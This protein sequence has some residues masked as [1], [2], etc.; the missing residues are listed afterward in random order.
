M[1]PCAC[2]SGQIDFQGAAAVPWNRRFWILDGRASVFRIHASGM[3]SGMQL[4]DGLSR[5]DWL[6]VGGLG[7]LGL[8]LPALLQGRASAAT[9][10][11]GL[12]GSFGKTKS[13]II[14]GLLGGP[15]QHETWDPKPDAPVEVRGEFKHIDS[16]LPGL[17]V[18]ELM[19]QVAQIA[20]KLAVLRAVST[21]DNAHSSSGYAMLTGYPHIPTNVENAR[22][23]AP[24]NYPC[25]GAIVNALRRERKGLPVSVTLPEHIWNTGMIPWPGQDA[26][27]LGRTLDPWLLTCDPSAADY[28]V[29]DL[30]FPREVPPLRFD[31]RRSLLAEVNR[32]LDGIGA[33]PALAQ[34]QNQSLQALDLLNAGGSR[35]AFDIAAEPAAVRDR[36]GRTRF[37]Q[38]ALLAR[39]L[40][41]AGV[42][43]VQVNWTRIADRANDGS[44]DTHAR[45]NDS[46]KTFLM[47]MIDQTFS[48]LVEDLDERGLL[49]ETLVV[50]LGEFGRTPKFNA[51]AG[52]DHWGPVF[53]LALAGGGI[54]AGVVHG[55]SDTL[56]AQPASG[57]VAPFDF[58]ATLFHCLGFR[59]ETE[60]RDTQGRPHPI[61]RGEVIRQI[62]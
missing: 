36:Y 26:G 25:V 57:R 6:H 23:G 48:A 45:N 34:Y 39:R 10:A 37:G 32:H 60:I 44:W 4:C 12:E 61:S 19:P 28:K 30:S 5:R 22:P 31:G 56:G 1:G 24:N 33:S 38:S 43:L 9:Q 8:S 27:F 47:P 17:S 18:C 59:P 20:H 11:E 21:G 3:H 42:S 62:I 35:R 16:S 58:T 53:S 29:P 41:E 54:R 55:A 40:V 14:L 50:W 51:A 46:L 49:D 13:C 2:Y 52:R 7:A 15:P